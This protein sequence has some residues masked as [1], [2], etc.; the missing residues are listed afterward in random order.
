M[1]AIVIDAPNGGAPVRI[2][3]SAGVAGMPADGESAEA[4]ISRADARLLEAK[5]NGRNFVMGPRTALR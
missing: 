3:F 1:D 4:L 2:T 5:A